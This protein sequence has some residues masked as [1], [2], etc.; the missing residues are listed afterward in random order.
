PEAPRADV[1]LASGQALQLAAVETS[2]AAN[3]RDEGRARFPQGARLHCF[4][5]VDKQAVI[6][7][8]REQSE[9]LDGPARLVLVTDDA[10]FDALRLRALAHLERGA[11]AGAGVYFREQPIGGETAFVFAGAGAAYHGMGRELLQRFPQ[12][13]ERLA[14]RSRRLPGALAWAH[15]D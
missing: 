10:G 2:D 6:A 5:G 13:R 3:D 7:A 11:P 1:R 14:A 4:A 9:S 12:L 8:V 15:A